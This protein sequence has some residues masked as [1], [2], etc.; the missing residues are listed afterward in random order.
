M[1]SFH[2]HSTFCDGK[3]TPEE[4]VLAALERGFSSIG[5]S[6]HGYTGFDVR[7]CMQD[8][9]G[10]VSEIRRLKEKYKSKIQVYLGIEEDMFAQADRSQFD[11]IIGSSHYFY[12]DNQYFPIDSDY[13]Y[14]QQCLELFQYDTEALAENYFRAF[15]NYIST[16]KP[17]II[18]H[19]DLITKFEEAHPSLFL[20]NPQ[21]NKIAE[22]YI[23][24]AAENNCIFEINTGAMSRGLRTTPYPSENLLRVLKGMDVRIILSSDSHDVETLDFGFDEAKRYLRD[25][26]FCYAW[27]L[28]DSEFKKYSL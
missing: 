18:G 23:K 10:Y 1:Y 14:F 11:Y 13:G 26:G 6:G 24:N 19:F 16:R 9:A 3:N 20:Q 2:I 4:I 25:I 8:T 15:C 17:D 27:A 12:K 22:M 7:Y 28:V 5:F 21:Y